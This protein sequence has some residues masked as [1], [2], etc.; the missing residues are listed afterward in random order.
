MSNNFAIVFLIACI[1]SSFGI[2]LIEFS[3]TLQ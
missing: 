2:V 3:K 1:Y